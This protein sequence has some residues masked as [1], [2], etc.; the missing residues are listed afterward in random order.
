MQHINNDC[1]LKHQSIKHRG[2]K[3]IRPTCESCIYKETKECDNLR[4]WR[5]ARQTKEDLLK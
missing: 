4:M 5:G 3:E 1:I 2:S